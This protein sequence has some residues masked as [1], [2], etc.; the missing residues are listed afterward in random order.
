MPEVTEPAIDLK[1]G[2]PQIE[3]FIDRDKAY[4]LGLNIYTIG[5]EIRANID[6]IVASKFREA[7]N[8]YD[9]LVILDP[10]DRDAVRDL[11]KIFVLNSMGKRIPLSNFVRLEKTTGPIDIK[12][13]N[14]MRT[15]H[16]TG[17]L[18]KKIEIDGRKKSVKLNETEMKIRRLIKSEIP[19]DDDLIIDFSG[20]YAD[21][22]EY[23]FKLILILLISIALVFGVMASQFESFLDPFIIIFTIPLMFIGVVWMYLFTGEQLN[24]LSIVGLVVL[25]GIVVNNGIVLVDYTNLLVKRGLTII[26]ACIEAGRNRLRPILMTTLTTILGLLPMALVKVEGAEMSRPIAKTVVGGLTISTIF[27]LFLIPV[28]YS[29]FNQFSE[30][31]KLKRMIIRQKQLKIRKQKLK[32][33]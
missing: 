11:E 5:Q 23:G 24:I 31:R 26:E 12:R 3:I 32:E 14:Q 10:K 21:M 17:G 22:M 19:Q 1:E 2:L 9:I 16:L 20:D 13:E 8:E 33:V 29:I 18:S 27:T 7:G 25:V 28:V 30:K 4:S 6:G 15:I